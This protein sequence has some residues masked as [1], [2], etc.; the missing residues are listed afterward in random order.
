V[1]VTPKAWKLGSDNQKEDELAG[2]ALPLYRN[3]TAQK[4]KKTIIFEEVTSAGR[5]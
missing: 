1:L 4:N 2:K 3:K 5:N